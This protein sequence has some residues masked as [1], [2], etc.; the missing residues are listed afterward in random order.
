MPQEGA[1][2]GVLLCAL[3]IGVAVGTLIGAVFLR[4]AVA[5]Y[6]NLAG[7]VS[8]P[9]S[10]PVPDFRKA[11]WITFSIS[12][13]QIIVGLLIDGL[14]PEARGVVAKLFIPEARGLVAKLFFLPVSLLI[15]VWMLSARL[16][17]TFGRALLVTLCDMFLV[18]LVAAVLVGIAALVFVVA[19]KGA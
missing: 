7:G 16:P 6:N 18:I 1:A 4:A 3:V 19:L 2:I 8:S 9:H 11:L 12:V 14:I 17:T 13:V 5:L 15:M 10:V